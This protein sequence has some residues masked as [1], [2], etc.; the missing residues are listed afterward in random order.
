MRKT[1]GI[2][3][4]IWFSLWTAHSLCWAEQTLVAKKVDQALVIDGRADEAAWAQTPAVVTHDKVANIDMTLKALYDKDKVYLLVSYPDKTE[5][6]LQKA[7]VWNAKEEV[8]EQGPSREDT[9]EFKWNLQSK[10]IDLH[11]DSDD[12][13]ETDVWYWKA[14]RTDSGGYADDKIDRLSFSEL[15][16]SRKVTSRSGK[17]LYVQRLG[18]EGREA[19]KNTLFTDHVKDVMPHFEPQEPT[20]SRADVRAKGVWKEGSWTVEFARPLKTGHS[21][22]VQFDLDKAYQFGV[23]RYEIAGRPPEPGIDEPLFGSGDV[24]E[25]LYLSFEQ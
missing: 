12:P 20:G 4:G 16:D 19:Y 24:S 9:I 15:P 21:D 1:L 22:D 17:T 18:D 23:S 3:V 10:P 6:R 7:W 11:I 13:S 8:Y 14:D 25:D 5:S 2:M